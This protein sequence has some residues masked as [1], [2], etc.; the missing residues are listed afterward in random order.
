MPK[1]KEQKSKVVEDLKLAITTAQGI[2][3]VDFTNVSANDFNNFRRRA[4]KEGVAVKVVKNRLALRALRECLMPEKVEDFLRG[5][6]AIFFAK[7]DPVAPARLLKEAESLSLNF[8]GAFLDNTIYTQDQFDF[9]VT[10][11]SKTEARANLVGVLASPISS[12]VTI[13]M[14]VISQLVWC[15]E[16]KSKIAASKPLGSV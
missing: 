14:G 6:T 8:K 16:E 9:L 2:Y 7:D 5:P 13:L 15:L 4:K 12:L 11:P 10:L 3:F 1:D